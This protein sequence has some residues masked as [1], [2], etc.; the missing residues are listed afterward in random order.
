MYTY[1]MTRKILIAIFE[2]LV[3]LFALGGISQGYV[4]GQWEEF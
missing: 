1:G 3:A 2:F 4:G